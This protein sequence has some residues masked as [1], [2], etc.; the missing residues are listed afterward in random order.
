MWCGLE[1]FTNSWFENLL[2]QEWLPTVP[3][4]QA[5]LDN[6]AAM[7]GVV[8]VADVGSGNGRALIKLAQAYPKSRFVGYDDFAGAGRCGF[9]HLRVA[10]G[11]DQGVL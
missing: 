8:G 1:R 7:A 2:L 3:D 5:K 4:V 9:R 11:K 6:G 10:R